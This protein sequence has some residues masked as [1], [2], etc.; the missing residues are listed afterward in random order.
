MAEIDVKKTQGSEQRNEQSTG[1]MQTRQTGGGLAPRGSYFP[2]LFSLS[3]RD[4]FTASPFEL[5]RRFTDEMDRAFESFG[6]MRGFGSGEMDVWTPAI[7]VFERDGNFVVRAELPGLNKEDVKVEM[8]DDG[9]IIQGERKREHEEKGESFYRSERSYGRFYR[10]VPLP[11]DANAEQVRASFNNGV[12]EV[13]MPVPE[14]KTNR[15]EIPIETGGGQSQ[16]V[17]TGKSK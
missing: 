3:P 8:T 13:S 10:L 12:L 11:E 5:M 4:F 1:A 16:A 15:R 7:E 14:R 6:L 9:L 17:T 2:S